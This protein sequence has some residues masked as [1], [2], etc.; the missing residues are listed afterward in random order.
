MAVETFKWKVER[1]ITPTIDYRVIETTFGDGY[2]QLSADG[3]N[4]K[5]A[6]YTIR[7]HARTN[8]AIEIMSFFDRHKGIKSFFWTP[9]LDTIGLFTCRD[10][11][12]NDEGGGLYSITGTFVK[13]Y[14]SMGA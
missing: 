13:S 10:P 7:V 5:N 3:I 1:N 11:A 2:K 9:P 6:S 4:T 12:W 14:S 8:E